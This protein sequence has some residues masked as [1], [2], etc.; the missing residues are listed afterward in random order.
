M[1]NE[2]NS[3]LTQEL[4]K[5]SNCK[6][7]NTLKICPYCFSKLILHHACRNV[8]EKEWTVRLHGTVECIYPRYL[9]RKLNYTTR[10]RDVNA[11]AN[12]AL[13]GA[14]IVLAADCQPLPPFCCNSSNQT[15]YNLV[16]ELSS[17]STS[18]LV[19]HD[20]IRDEWIWWD[21]KF[22]AVLFHMLTLS[23]FVTACPILVEKDYDRL[24]RKLKRD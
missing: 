7:F 3:S 24:A 10:G 15:R 14:S 22:L 23:C 9:A 1:R 5:C 8:N 4:W 13:S 21:L 19:P 6:K 20:F 2:K 16:K 17:V 11:S 12:I 18:G